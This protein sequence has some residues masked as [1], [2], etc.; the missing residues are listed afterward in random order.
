[1]LG[2]KRSGP[3]WE[4]L[5]TLAACHVA[6][7]LEQAL[8]LMPFRTGVALAHGLHPIHPA[9]RLLHAVLSVLL[10]GTAS[11]VVAHSGWGAA[12]AAVAKPDPVL[13]HQALQQL[14]ASEL[15]LHLVAAYLSCCNRL[16]EAADLLE[17]AR[18]HGYH[19][20]ETTKLAVDVLYRSGKA[21]AARALAQAER[22]LLSADDWRAIE[23]A[24][25]S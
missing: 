23:S 13:A 11:V 6:W 2:Q 9:L 3:A 7:G 17:L 14:P 5:A 12:W 25:S 22:Q 8:P 20:A 10:I 19:A 24:T 16:D 21:A 15:D 4:A 18:R 1:M